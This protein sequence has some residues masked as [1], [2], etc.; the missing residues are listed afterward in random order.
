MVKILFLFLFTFLILPLLQ[1]KKPFQK[2]E[3][4][5]N[6]KAFKHKKGDGFQQKKAFKHTPEMLKK[7]LP[8]G[9][10]VQ[11]FLKV[12]T[13]VFKLHLKKIE[14]K[15]ED[16]VKINKALVEKEI[17]RIRAKAEK[18]VTWLTLD[19]LLMAEKPDR[20]SINKQ[21]ENYLE[22][23]KQSLLGQVD[24]FLTIRE[25]LPENLLENWLEKVQKL[26]AIK[27][28]KA[29]KK[30]KDKPGRGVL[31]QRVQ[32]RIR[33]AEIKKQQLK[34]QF[35]REL[36]ENFRLFQYLQQKPGFNQGEMF[37]K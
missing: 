30:F 8:K 21:I 28:M 35:Q 12:P 19:L 37:E 34:R 5:G 14:M 18:K 23:K 15:K 6:K 27:N 17:A 3:R 33:Q 36:K 9:S 13:E 2:W 11:A 7:N 4:F 24:F 1:A 20:D 22:S 16:R 25:L 10:A 26:Q 29:K 32:N 31:R